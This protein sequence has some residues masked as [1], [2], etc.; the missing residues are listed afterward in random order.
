MKRNIF[1]GGALLLCSMIFGGNFAAG[2][3]DFMDESVTIPCPRVD[4]HIT[5]ET[6]EVIRK[7]LLETLKKQQPPENYAHLVKEAEKAKP[8]ILEGN[9]AHIGAWKLICRGNALLLERQQ[10]PRAPQ[11]LFFEAPLEWRDGQ[12]HV[13]SVNSVRVRGKP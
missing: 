13:L 6:L 9:N 3:K 12:W 2:E 4:L 8:M 5:P 10:I 11:M 7:K 1:L